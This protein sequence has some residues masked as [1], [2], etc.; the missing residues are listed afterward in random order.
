MRENYWR[1]ETLE[2]GEAL[3][4]AVEKQENSSELSILNFASA[5][6]GH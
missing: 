1:R 6:S 5:L 4:Q 3:G 2:D